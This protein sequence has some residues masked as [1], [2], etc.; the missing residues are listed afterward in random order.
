MALFVPGIPFPIQYGIV[1]V[2]HGR[3]IKAITIA[4]PT[5]MATVSLTQK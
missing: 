3:E 4:P 1:V 2:D 5:S